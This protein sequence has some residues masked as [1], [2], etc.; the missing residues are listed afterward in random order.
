MRGVGRRER[1]CNQGL[2]A[3][4]DPSA[5]T[6]FAGR[7]E[8]DGLERH[9]NAVRDIGSRVDERAVEVE[10]EQLGSSRAQNTRTAISAGA[11]SKSSISLSSFSSVSDAPAIS[12]DV[13]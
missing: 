7:V 10:R 8:A 3:V 13:Q 2:D 6:R 12:S 4:A 11:A 9:A 5:R 1:A